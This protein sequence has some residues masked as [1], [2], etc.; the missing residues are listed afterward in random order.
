MVKVAV[1]TKSLPLLFFSLPHATLKSD[2]P[3][4]RET[5]YVPPLRETPC[6]TC[7]P[8]LS[9]EPTAA[10]RNAKPFTALGPKP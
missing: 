3:A 8:S 7:P 10:A 1:G 2:A 4:L 9:P 5:V 6:S